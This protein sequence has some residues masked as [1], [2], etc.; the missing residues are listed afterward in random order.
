M[1]RPQAYLP[2]KNCKKYLTCKLLLAHGQNPCSHGVSRSHWLILT[3]AGAGQ[4]CLQLLEPHHYQKGDPFWM[5]SWW[6]CSTVLLELADSCRPMPPR[7]AVRLL[8]LGLATD[9][10]FGGTSGLLSRGITHFSQSFCF[11]I[12]APCIYRHTAPYISARAKSLLKGL[13]TSTTSK[14]KYKCL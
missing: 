5:K 14:M 3:A 10:E 11:L 1:R 12:L 13:Y 2:S 6:F 9:A 8:T 7:R 4:S